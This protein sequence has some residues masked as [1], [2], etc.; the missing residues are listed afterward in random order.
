MHFNLINI[1]N[2]ILHNSLFCK[3]PYS[4]YNFKISKVLYK[5]GLVSHYKILKTKK[6]ILL[7]LKYYNNI[8]VIRDFKIL[9]TSS[10]YISTNSKVL[11]YRK[12][13]LLV[14]TSKGIFLSNNVKNYNIGGK[15]LFFI[16][17]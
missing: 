4:N 15:V 8:N 17:C 13:S 14:S 3:L 6:I 11:I 7:Y 12:N 16:N 2:S 10:K 5:N 9:S 1:K